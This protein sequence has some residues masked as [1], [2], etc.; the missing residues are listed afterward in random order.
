MMSVRILSRV[1]TIVV[2]LWVLRWGARRC[3][4]IEIVHPPEPR[5]VV[6]HR[7]LNALTT[8]LSYISL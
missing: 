4:L 1:P 3:E 6:I 5:P 7:N 8:K 2:F